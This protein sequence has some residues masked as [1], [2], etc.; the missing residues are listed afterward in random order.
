VPSP[1]VPVLPAPIEVAFLNSL[2]VAALPH[3]LITLITAH[4]RNVADTAAAIGVDP[5]LILRV[6]T[7]RQPM[8]LELVV[9]IAQYLNCDPSLVREA[10]PACVQSSPINR[11]NRTPYPPDPTLGDPFRYQPVAPYVV[12]TPVIG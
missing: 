8:P 2:L 10:C 7:S 5:D 4:G 12:P 6:D 3:H 1:N 9:P 11:V